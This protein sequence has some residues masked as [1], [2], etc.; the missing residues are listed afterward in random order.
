MSGSLSMRDTLIWKVDSAEFATFLPPY[1]DELTA[2]SAFWTTTRNRDEVV[3]SPHEYKAVRSTD[4][5]R[6]DDVTVPGVYV[7]E[8]GLVGL[9]V[10]WQPGDAP[11]GR[12]STPLPYPVIGSKLPA[13]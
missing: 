10:L 11:A 6:R 4:L 5:L 9:L 7:V 12:A 8:V 2:F 13:L 1:R 3:R